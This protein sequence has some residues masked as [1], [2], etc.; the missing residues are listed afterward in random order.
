MRLRT[1]PGRAG[2][3]WLARRLAVADRGARV[4]DDKRRALL[5]E[6]GRFAALVEETRR[7][8]EQA[9]AEAETWQR[10]ALLISGKRSLDLACFY[11][12]EPA[13]VRVAWRRSM[14]ATYPSDVEI[15]IPPTP[16]LVAPGGSAAL[17]FAA[18]AHGRAVEAGAQHAAARLALE[19]V[20]AE[21]AT[22]IRRLRAL[23]RRWIPAH[24]QALAALTL[25]LD[26]GERE[27][28]VRARWFAEQGAGGGSDV[29]DDAP[30]PPR[31]EARELEVVE[32]HPL[33]EVGR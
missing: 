3:Q 14:G 13:V 26:E 1:P 27:D 28:A 20:E 24:E 18:S 8:W 9:V 32:R 10:R 5:R 19:R 6:R 15:R 23:E 7:A 16:D 33:D 17:P 30:V 2:R 11:T 25:A 21:L 12:G 4:L 29:E 22:T 31:A